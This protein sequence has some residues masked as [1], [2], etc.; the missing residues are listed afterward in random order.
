M[1]KYARASDLL[2]VLY[3]RPNITFGISQF[4]DLI[5]A[6]RVGG[7]APSTNYLFLGMFSV[8]V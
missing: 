3:R 4:H 6:F 2:L 8:L 7:Q 1:G 5:E